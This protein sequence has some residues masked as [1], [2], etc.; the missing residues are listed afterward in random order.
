MP[1]FFVKHPQKC[2]EDQ[3]TSNLFFFCFES[4]FQIFKHKKNIPILGQWA[5]LFV[6]ID[7]VHQQGCVNRQINAVGKVLSNKVCHLA[8]V[9]WPR[10]NGPTQDSGRVN[11]RHEGALN[12]GLTI[13][14]PPEFFQVFFWIF[15][16]FSHI[17]SWNILSFPQKLLKKVT[18]WEHS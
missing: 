9:G 3:M 16:V 17:F 4:S 1:I 6:E 14:P 11:S 15:H 5:F 10:K 12:L 7:V 13:T 18:C 2:W 8:T